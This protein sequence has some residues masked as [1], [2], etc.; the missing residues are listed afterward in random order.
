MGEKKF[1]LFFLC[2]VFMAG[3]ASGSMTT[4]EKSTV[5][6]ALLGAG[7]GAIIGAVNDDA[8]EGAAVG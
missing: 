1:F 3:C 8:A 5:R 2:A 6:G 7:T 4:R